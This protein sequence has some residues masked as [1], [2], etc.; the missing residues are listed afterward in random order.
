MGTGDNEKEEKSCGE[1]KWYEVTKGKLCFWTSEVI[2][3]NLTC[4]SYITLNISPLLPIYTVIGCDVYFVII[5]ICES[6]ACLFF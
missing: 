6:K 2:K 1:R 3:L 4:D 5:D